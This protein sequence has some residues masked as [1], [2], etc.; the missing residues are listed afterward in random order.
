MNETQ[1]TI[2]E[3]YSCRAYNDT[4]LTEE[5]IKTLAEAALASPSAINRQPWRVIIVTDKALLEAMDAEAL[6]VI[7]AQD[8]NWHAQVMKR[9][10]TIFYNAP[11]MVMIASDGSDHA[12]A[13][14]GILS[15]NVALA[16]QA[17]GLGNVICGM[18]RLPLLGARGQEFSQK[19]GFPEGFVFGMAVLVG[20]TDEPGEPH[21]LDWGKI[22]YV[23]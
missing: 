13:D 5:Q 6:N 17:M 21:E 16:A 12:A 19:L 14:C 11:C 7:K 22:S 4:P 1:K 18:A 9:G 20:N 3:R 23:R 2:T 10:G 8:E 15:E